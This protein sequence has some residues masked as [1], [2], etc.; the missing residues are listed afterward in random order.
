MTSREG[1]RVI[2]SQLSAV[3]YQQSA[4][5]YQQSA[6]SSQLSAV[7]GRDVLTRIDGKLKADG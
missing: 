2:S 7:M 3:S 5:S 1:G 4:V 6:I